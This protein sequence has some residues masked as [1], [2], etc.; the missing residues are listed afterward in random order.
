VAYLGKTLGYGS[1]E[2]MLTILRDDSKVLTDLLYKFSLW[3]NRNSV[4]IFCFFEQ[5]ET[6][7]GTRARYLRFQPV[8]WKSL[9]RYETVALIMLT[10]IQVV[11][12]S[13]ACIDGHQK[14]PLPTDHFKI[15]KFSGP[16]DPSYR[17]LSPILVQ[18]CNGANEK[19]MSRINRVYILI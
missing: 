3:V 17:A 1:E 11:G 18:I 4:E 8:S 5:H 15:N 10:M 12:E 14:I 2:Q 16:Q 9:V 19:V 6:D 13:T 7:Y